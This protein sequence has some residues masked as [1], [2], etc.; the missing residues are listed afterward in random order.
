MYEPTEQLFGR[1]AAM[2]LATDVAKNTSGIPTKQAM[3]IAEGV[4]QPLQGGNGSGNGSSNSEVIARFKQ[5]LQGDA[6][7]PRSPE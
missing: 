5:L 4:M 6:V 1:H 7:A 2:Q 3:K